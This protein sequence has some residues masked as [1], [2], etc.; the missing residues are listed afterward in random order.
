MEKRRQRKQLEEPKALHQSSLIPKQLRRTKDKT[1]SG[2]PELP[3][4]QNRA[5]SGRS[6]LARGETSR[7][8]SILAGSEDE[9]PLLLLALKAPLVDSFEVE[10]SVAAYPKGE[11]IITVFK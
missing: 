2:S 9:P 10:A 4:Q 1:A 7:L 3:H 6:Q 8:N 5:S 11:L